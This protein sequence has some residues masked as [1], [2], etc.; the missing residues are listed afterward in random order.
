MIDDL[1]HF[2]QRELDYLGDSAAAFAAANPVV[3]GR[4]NLSRD[5]IEDPHV[6]RLI[7]SV[8]FLNARLRHK[9]DDEF[10]DL[11]D[12]LI[13]TLYPHLIAPLP[14]FMVAQFEPSPDLVAPMAVPR[15]TPI[16]AQTIDG[17]P[18]RYETAAATQIHPLRLTSVT[19]AG[20]PYPRPGGAPLGTTGVL[21]VEIEGL[22]PEVDIAKLGLDRLRF[23]IRGDS[24]K[25]QI[26]AEQLGANL[27]GIAVAA[28][29]DDPNA[30]LLPPDALRNLGFEAE[31]LLLP[32]RDHGQR[33]F[34]ILQEFFAYPRKHL[35]FE[36]NGMLA[37]TASLRGGKLH[38]FFLLDRLSPELE[39]ILNS[40]DL[41]LH[42]VPLINLFEADREPVRLDQ[43]ATEYRVSPG[44][45]R[46]QA[47]EVH[48][49]TA[50]ELIA[51]DGTRETIAPLYDVTQGGQPDALFYATQRRENL[52]PDGGTDLFVSIAD[53]AGRL[54]DDPDAKALPVAL[55]FNR[56]LPQ[57]ELQGAGPRLESVETINGLA[58]VHALGAPTPTRRPRRRAALW[59][60]V[61]QLSL[62]HLS[63]SG[64]RSG[65]T[66]LQTV[67][68]LYDVEKSR[69]SRTLR[70]RLI[71][72]N[73]S[74][75]VARTRVA[76]HQLLCSG[77]AVQLT[78]KDERLAGNGSYLLC[79]AIERFLALSASINSFVRVSARLDHDSQPWKVWAPRVG[80]R[81]LL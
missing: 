62:N 24:R 28:T 8:A 46:E 55:A 22:T 30:L 54:L 38:L 58:A 7:Q 49:V 20:D 81:E 16:D 47:L 17:A 80:E 51:A 13:E 36:L 65:A 53:R 59:Q 9:I 74:A 79:A 71:E 70:N 61:S 34:A 52:G 60:L 67:L 41:A 43:T 35:F 64:G 73:A 77:T 3:A 75:D 23:F 57:F 10:A 40:D 44:I 45:E 26:L 2:Y 56:S 32:Q 15:G 72:V 25:A 12:A 18:C 29:P 69:E 11:S 21:H 1:I 37:R 76:G 50:L 63:F 39:R 31:G 78:I 4:L 6:E 66:A 33:P 48:S 42:A 27:L 68:E 14:S 5:K 19:M